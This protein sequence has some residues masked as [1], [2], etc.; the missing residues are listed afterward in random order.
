M[1]GFHHKNQSCLELKIVLPIENGEESI[2]LA[3]KRITAGK[4]NILDF[5][6]SGVL[7]IKRKKSGLLISQQLRL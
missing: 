2:N 3:I 4:I 7:E 1:C 6:L 5:I